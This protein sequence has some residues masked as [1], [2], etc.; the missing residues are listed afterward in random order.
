MQ[1]DEAFGAGKETATQGAVGDAEFS[2]RSGER[3][4]K[5]DVLSASI[6]IR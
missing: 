4:T 3:E 5:R 1:E 6:I 2:E